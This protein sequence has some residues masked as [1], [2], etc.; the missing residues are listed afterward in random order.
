MRA[1]SAISLTAT[2]LRS[3]WRTRLAAP[4][5]Y[6]MPRWQQTIVWQHQTPALIVPTASICR[7]VARA[8]ASNSISYGVTRNGAH[9]ARAT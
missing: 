2:T 3:V 9:I 7:N 5:S 1:A 4:L 6:Y 8:Y